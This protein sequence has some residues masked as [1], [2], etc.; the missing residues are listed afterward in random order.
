MSAYNTPVYFLN[1]YLSCSLHLKYPLVSD[2]FSDSPDT[3]GAKLLSTTTVSY[4]SFNIQLFS[5]ISVVM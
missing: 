2:I 4:S 1:S 3:P 5:C